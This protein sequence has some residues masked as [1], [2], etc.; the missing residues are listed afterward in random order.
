MGV[1]M[2]W[3]VIAA[4]II[5]GM[6]M[7]QHGRRRIF[8][9]AVMAVLH[10][11]VSGFRYMYLTGDLKKYGW[12]YGDYLNHGYFSEQ[13][14]NKGINTGFFWF[15][16]LVSTLTDGDFQIFLVVIAV[17][18]E[19]A[20]AVLVYKYSPRPW[21][22]YLVWNCMGFYVFG[23]SALKQ[24]LAMAFIMVAM[25]SILQNRVGVFLMITTIAG[26]I[27]FPAFAFIP[28]YWIAKAR[29]RPLSV[30][31][32][33]AAAILIFIFQG[34]IV[35]F[36]SSI[37]YE[38]GELMLADQ[39]D[40]GGRFFM[41]VVILAMGICLKGFSDRRFEKLFNIMVVAAVFQMF[42]G[43]DNIFTRFSDYY[44]QMSI[45]FLPLMVSSR[46]TDA[47]L[48]GSHRQAIFPFNRRSL[49]VIA[50]L[51]AVY[52]VWYYNRTCLSSTI[53]YEVDNYLNYRFMWD[54]K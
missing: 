30:L 19:I 20:A 24:S 12:S 31:G 43:F 45:L 9:I 2:Y 8:Y 1:I 53:S 47:Q 39:A 25:D 49:E 26:C 6:V 4:V 40:L 29:M 35:R 5:L 7:P 37:Y 41:M 48:G 3:I 21:I 23:F 11:F 22:S 15:S 28:A 32:Y 10:A 16:K 50:I 18:I 51:M 17:I 36:I 54:V 34:P 27:H 33:I 46:A 14:L 52:L 38:E 44:F 13:V 42:S